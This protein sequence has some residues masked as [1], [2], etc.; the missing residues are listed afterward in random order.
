MF[1]VQPTVYFEGMDPRFESASVYGSAGGTGEK[2]NPGV[3]SVGILAVGIIGVAG[4]ATALF[5]EVR[6]VCACVLFRH[7][8]RMW[9]RRRSRLAAAGGTGGGGTAT[10]LFHK[11]RRLAS[12]DKREACGLGACLSSCTHHP[13]APAPHACLPRCRPCGA[14]PLAVHAGGL[15]HSACNNPWHYPSENPPAQSVVGLVAFWVALGGAAA[16]FGFQYVNKLTPDAA[17]KK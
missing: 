2:L 12:R 8:W 13:A 1:T 10:T 17:P 3:V 14:P 9:G 5:Y 15:H 4:T 16:F 6:R 7:G 11:V